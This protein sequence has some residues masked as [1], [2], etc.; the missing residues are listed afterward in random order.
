MRLRVSTCALAALLV[1]CGDAPPP[2]GPR[3]MAAAAELQPLAGRALQGNVRFE[4]TGAGVHV[5]A[6]R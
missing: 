6:E 3:A 4:Q 5:S 1:G 2:A